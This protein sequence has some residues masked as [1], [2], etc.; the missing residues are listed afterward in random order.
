MELL[1]KFLTHKLMELILMSAK[2]PVGL[3]PFVPVLPRVR[4]CRSLL[5]TVAFLLF[6]LYK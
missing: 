1:I 4:E 3:F 6:A 2:F 5:I